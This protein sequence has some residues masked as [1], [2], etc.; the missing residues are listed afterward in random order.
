[1]GLV[2][3]QGCWARG[4]CHRDSDKNRKQ[5]YARNLRPLQRIGPQNS[6]HD[7]RI[8]CPGLASAGISR[9]S[10]ARQFV[11]SSERP[12]KTS[13]MSIKFCQIVDRLLA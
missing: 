10:W 11:F 6:S 2:L 13:I 8:L 4:E 12:L 3:P 7:W 9:S 1:V 5:E